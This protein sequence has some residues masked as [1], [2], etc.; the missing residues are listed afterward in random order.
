MVINSNKLDYLLLSVK[1]LLAELLL[2]NGSYNSLFEIPTIN[3]VRDF[4]FENKDSKIL[5]LHTKGISQTNKN[6]NDWIEMMLYFLIDK[7]CIDLLNEYDTLGCNY[8]DGLH[9]L[10][11]RHYSGNFWWATTNYLSRLPKCVGVKFEAEFWLLKSPLAKYKVLHNS[12][13][14][15]YHDSY[16]RK[17]YDFISTICSAW[18]GHRDFAEWLVDYTKPKTI[19]ELGVDWG[20]SSFVFANANKSTKVY[21]V[22]LFTGDD[23]TCY[24]DTYNSVM[25][26][27]KKHNLSNLEIIKGD[28][29]E[30]SKTWNIPIDIL[31]IDGFH[32]YD[33]VKNDFTNWS[34]FVNN[35]GVVLFHDTAVEYF[36]IKDFFNELPNDYKLSFSHSAGLG[37][38][39]KNKELYNV[40][41]K[42]FDVADYSL[43]IGFHA[44][45][46]LCERGTDVAMFDY[47][48]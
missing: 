8:D 1:N 48:Y 7:D 47:A 4:A 17:N 28:F 45:G 13:K 30:V 2:S 39:T 5:Y 9:G 37:I 15:H 11:P 35:N 44:C 31:H 27:I 42:K 34:K 14:N 29:T 18:T 41:K 46:H 10:H 40:I 3:K 26:N 32:T 6:I 16:P 24:R 43:K 20:F 38:Y 33:A 36:G 22:D 19:V 23:H 12:G 21:G 25:E